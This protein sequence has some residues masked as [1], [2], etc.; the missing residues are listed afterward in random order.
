MTL[1]M[2]TNICCIECI[3]MESQERNGADVYAHKSLSSSVYA[4]KEPLLIST[5]PFSWLCSSF[6][7]I[8]SLKFQFYTK[9]LFF[10]LNTLQELV[11][12]SLFCT[13]VSR[14]ITWREITA[15]KLNI[16]HVRVCEH[17]SIV[18]YTNV[19]LSNNCA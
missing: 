10:V 19:V 8:H 12:V 1:K 6:S 18:L 9:E 14:V 4:T 13:G 7:G 3:Q 2:P 5:V 16:S 11:W 15:P 17:F